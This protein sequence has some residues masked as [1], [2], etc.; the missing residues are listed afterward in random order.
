MRF[1]A[2]VG[3][4]PLRSYFALTFGISWGGIL[5]VLGASEFNLTVLRPLDTGLMFVVMLLGPSTAGLAM[6]GLL[7]GRQGMRLLWS[8]TVHWRVGLW[9]YLLVLMTMPVLLLATL[10]P[11]SV[12]VHPSFAPQFQWSLFAIGLVTGSIEELGWTGFATPRLL[13]RQRLCAA[14][15]SLG[16][17]WA[18]WHVLVDFRQNFY[19]LGAAWVLEFAVFF[20]GALTAYRLLMT[21]VYANTQSLLLA[22]LMHASYTGWLLVLYPATST[23][24]G[25]VWQTMFALALWLVVAAVLFLG[26]RRRQAR[27]ITS[28]VRR[29]RLLQ[30]PRCEVP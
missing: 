16:L 22:M 11:L 4:Y 9:W 25:M 13:A 7:E 6:T 19:S 2:W 12:F 10:W 8:R 26:P 24:Q 18:L 30:C 21:W 20:L 3:R 29:G 17:A 23:W 27:G 28:K 5:V 14:G 15:L 1:L